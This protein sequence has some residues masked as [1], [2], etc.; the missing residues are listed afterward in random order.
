VIRVASWGGELGIFSRV[1]GSIGGETRRE[2]A[3]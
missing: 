1:G 3:R 2:N